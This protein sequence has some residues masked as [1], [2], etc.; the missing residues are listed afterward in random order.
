VSLRAFSALVVFA[1][2]GC[3]TTPS[4]TVGVPLGSEF[5]LKP[6]E[7]ARVQSTDLRVTFVQVL[8]DSRCPGDA[9]CVW[10]GDAVLALRV[11]SADVELRSNTAPAQPVG[12]YTV[13]VQRVEPYPFTSKIIA[14]ADYRAVLV[15]TQH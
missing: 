1:A 2:V 14:P 5:I 10:A 7:T 12:T 6:G 9:L 13:R 4:S 11:G 3:S 15:V 8:N